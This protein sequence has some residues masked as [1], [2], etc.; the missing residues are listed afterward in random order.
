MYYV[1]KTGAYVDKHF[2]AFEPLLVEYKVGH[3]A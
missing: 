2:Q 3:V 1:D